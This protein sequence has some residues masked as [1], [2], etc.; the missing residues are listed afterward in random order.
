M[1]AR[2]PATDPDR[3]GELERAIGSVSRGITDPVA[4]L[5]YIRRSLAECQAADRHLRAV[6]S[7]WLRRVLYRILS[8]AGLRHAFDTRSLGYRVAGDAA[9]GRLLVLSRISVAAAALL[10]AMGLVAVA[11]RAS[12]PAARPVEASVPSPPAGSPGRPTPGRT[13]PRRRAWPRARCGWWRRARAS[14][15]TATACAS[16]PRS[17]SGDR[18]GATASSR[19]DGSLRRGRLRGPRRHPVPHVGERRLAARRAA[20]NENLRTAASDLLRYVQRNRLYHYL[21]DRFGRVFRVVDETRPRPTTPATRC[22]RRRD[23]PT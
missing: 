6:P 17:R 4:K 10:M 11:Y 22:G 18:P 19:A 20:F 14:S 2:P 8:I 3:G 1:T 13:C 23:A 21:I 16:T 15:S 7:P 5:R 12:R 9:G